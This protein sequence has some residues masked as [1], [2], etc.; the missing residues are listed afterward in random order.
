[1][2]EVPA[3]ELLARERHLPHFALVPIQPVAIFEDYAT[4]IYP[5]DARSAYS[6]PLDIPAQVFDH[7]VVTRK[8]L[9]R[10]D[11]PGQFPERRRDLLTQLL[12]QRLQKYG[13]KHL[14]KAIVGKHNLSVNA[15][16]LTILV[17]KPAEH[18]DVDVGEEVKFGIPSMQDRHEPDLPLNPTW[19]CSEGDQGFTHRLQQFV[20]ENGLVLPRYIVELSWNREHEVEIVRFRKPALRR[21]DPFLS[22]AIVALDAG[23]VPAGSI[24]FFDQ[25]A[26]GASQDRLSVSFGSAFIEVEQ[27]LLVAR[28]HIL[29][30]LPQVFRAELVE[31]LDELVHALDLNPMASRRI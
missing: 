9:L 6:D 16:V 25:A 21:I 19:A 22:L 26:V 10:I 31:D 8:I 14:G 20:V 18:H 3:K 1:M 11:H 29:F 13:F 28:R 23:A 12:P 15:L 27:S 5:N 24:L 7:V 30:V 4:L 17:Q 2:L